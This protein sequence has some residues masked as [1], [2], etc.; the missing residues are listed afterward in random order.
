MNVVAAPASTP[1]A[2]SAAATYALGVD[3][4][5][6]RGVVENLLL[7]SRF[8]FPAPPPPQ[9]CLMAL[10]LLLRLIPL[11]IR[12][13]RP[14]FIRLVLDGDILRSFRCLLTTAIAFLNR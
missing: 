10:L 13:P 11:L 2:T 1:T 14:R 12:Q 4:A 9:A 5:T 7:Q 3:I 8:R 6:T